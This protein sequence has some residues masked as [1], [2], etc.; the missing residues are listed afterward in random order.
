MGRENFWGVKDRV[1]N[2]YGDG[3]TTNIS[4]GELVLS[5]STING[6]TKHGLKKWNGGELPNSEQQPI[7]KGYNISMKFNEEEKDKIISAITSSNYPQT[8]PINSKEEETEIEYNPGWIII[9]PSEEGEGPY[10]IVSDKRDGLNKDGYLE[11]AECYINWT[12]TSGTV[13]HEAIY[14]GRSASGGHSD[15]A[16]VDPLFYSIGTYAGETPKGRIEF[17]VDRKAYNLSDEPTFVGMEPLDDIL[18]M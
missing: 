18:G 3:W 16:N 7:F 4:T 8:K 14:H 6:N 15:T 1:A 11:E 13:L 17:P 5:Y 9:R 2:E 12:E 10:A